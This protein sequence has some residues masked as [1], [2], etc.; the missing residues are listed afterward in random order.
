MA[1][2][3]WG[4]IHPKEGRG[5][6]AVTGGMPV[7]DMPAPSQVAIMLGQHVGAPCKPLVKAGQRVLMGQKIG[8]PAGFMGA[9][10]HASVSGTVKGIVTRTGANGTPGD[11][12]LI[13]NDG[14]DEWDPSV[15]P[16]EGDPLT[17]EKSVLLARIREC[18]CV[19]LGGACFPTQIKLS[20]PEDKPID[21]VILNGGECEPYLTSDH[22]TM[23]EK[24]GI[25]A[26]G[27]R[28][29][30]YIVGAKTGIVGIEDNKPDAIAPMTGAV[31]GIPGA[32]VMAL[33]AK[34]PQ[35]GEKQLIKAT[36]GREVPSGKLPMEAG[37]VVMNVSSAAAL[38]RAIREGVPVIER[39]V[40]VAGLV[41]KPM[42]V[43]VRV[44]TAIRELLAFCGG[45]AQEANRLIL[46]GPMMGM[47]GYD[48]DTPVVKGTGGVTVLYDAHQEHTPV[49]NCI[50]CGSCVEACPMHLMPIELNK[51]AARGRYEECRALHALDCIE[52]GS[53]SYVC[54]AKLPLVHNI[55]T[56]KRALSARKA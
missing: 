2:S 30:M 17:A 40:T 49:G 51:Q 15:V 55:R 19:G 22:R 5:G 21:Y 36:T 47:S 23:V 56:A 37:C 48:L 32:Q 7:T 31:S 52:C 25:V 26:D 14:K 27:L 6:K 9:P 33:K 12:I 4:G 54:P 28:L 29:A 20:P 10:V 53:C 16:F 41:A 43:R 46:G 45:T 42:N 24:A 34:Y 35:G 39:V 13:E 11:A 8:E 18:G 50:R 3:F 44:G 1:R 38:S